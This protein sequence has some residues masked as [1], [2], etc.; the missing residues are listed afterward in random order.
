MKAS[1]VKDARRRDA[2]CSQAKRAYEKPAVKE[3]GDVRELTLG[4]GI[5]TKIDGKSGVKRP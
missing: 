3:L 5:G 4:P 1:E 2:A